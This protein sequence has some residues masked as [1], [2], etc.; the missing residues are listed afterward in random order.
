MRNAMEH[1][2]PLVLALQATRRLQLT[3]CFGWWST[4]KESVSMTSFKTKRKLARKK[5]DNNSLWS[6]NY[7]SM[8]NPTWSMTTNM[9]HLQCS[10]NLKTLRRQVVQVPSLPTNRKRTRN[11]W[12]NRFIGSSQKIIQTYTET[13]ASTTHW[14]GWRFKITWTIKRRVVRSFKCLHLW[15]MSNTP[16][17]SWRIKMWY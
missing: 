11:H 12:G 8:W 9:W 16:T 3:P 15:T 17:S 1:L 14:E 5:I 6:L 4:G 10:T 13:L 2:R 7:R